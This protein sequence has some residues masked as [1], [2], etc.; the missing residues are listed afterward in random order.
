MKAIFRAFATIAALFL[1]GCAS[2]VTLTNVTK[3]SSSTGSTSTVYAITQ[4]A[5][6]S[7]WPTVEI[8]IKPLSGLTITKAT[9]VFAL[10][11]G[12]LAAMS[13]TNLGAWNYDNS[14]WTIISADSGSYFTSAAMPP[15]A[16]TWATSPDVANTTYSSTAFPGTTAAVLFDLWTTKPAASTLYVKQ[17]NLTY[18][19]SS[20]ETLTFT[21]TT[22]TNV[23]SVAGSST[24]DPTISSRLWFSTTTAAGLQ[25]T[26]FAT[27]PF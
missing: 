7:A 9:V 18:S 13:G 6:T 17:I 10:D 20:T 23:H 19:D 4:P 12:F 15:A 24:T 25:G 26:A 8:G 5:D 14:S 11:A 2:P 16:N 3:T 22:G 1:V 21:D 27:V